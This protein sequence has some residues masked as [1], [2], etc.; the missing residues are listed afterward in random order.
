M[1]IASQSS[2]EAQ[3]ASPP[4]AA[5][6]TPDRTPARRRTTLTRNRWGYAYVA[7]FFLLFAAF[8]LYPFIYTAWISLHKTSLSDI[9]GGT[10][11][12]LENYRNL[13]HNEF[14]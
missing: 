2:R 10:W 3:T 12:G 14:F 1:T 13:L 4:A 11:V 9:N 7:P 8:S 5:P 6:A